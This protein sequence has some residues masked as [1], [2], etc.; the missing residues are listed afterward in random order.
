[1]SREGIKSMLANPI[2]QYR[3]LLLFMLNFNFFSNNPLCLLNAWFLEAFLRPS[4][5]TAD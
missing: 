2:Y 4:Q 3:T 1:M 5:I